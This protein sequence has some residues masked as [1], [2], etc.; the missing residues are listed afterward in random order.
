MISLKPPRYSNQTSLGVVPGTSRAP[1]IASRRRIHKMVVCDSI[2]WTTSESVQWFVLRQVGF[3]IR[4]FMNV[5]KEAD[6]SDR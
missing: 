5:D 4:G 2:S 3:W 6:F 1:S